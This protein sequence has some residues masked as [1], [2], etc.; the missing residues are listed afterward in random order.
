MLKQIRIFEVTCKWT[1]PDIKN[2]TKHAIFQL[3]F[4]DARDQF[5]VRGPRRIFF[6]NLILIVIGVGVSVHDI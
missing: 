2:P 5:H 1:V 4:E 3:I 6:Y